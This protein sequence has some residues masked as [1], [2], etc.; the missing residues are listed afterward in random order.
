MATA[1]LKTIPHSLST[2]LSISDET[3]SD[4]VNILYDKFVTNQMAYEDILK[5]STNTV[6]TMLSSRISD[7][8]K[9][10]IINMALKWI[11]ER[12]LSDAK[13]SSILRVVTFGG[14]TY[15][16]LIAFRDTL[17]QSAVPVTI[18]RCVRVKHQENLIDFVFMHAEN[19]GI[20]T[21][22]EK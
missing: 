2:M 22:P 18:G 13:A 12:R 5:L 3:V 7:S 17:I 15:S 11:Y 10:E 9:V 8:K 21:M 1:T 6:I 16:Q 4:L 14:L 20:H 19:S